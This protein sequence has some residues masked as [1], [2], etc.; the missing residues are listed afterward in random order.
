[1]ILKPTSVHWILMLL[2]DKTYF[3]LDAAFSIINHSSIK[4]ADDKIYVC[5]I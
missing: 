1:M 3:L 2:G 4:T 5:N